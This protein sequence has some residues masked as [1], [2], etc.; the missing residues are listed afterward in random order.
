MSA[1]NVLLL[2]ENFFSLKILL[3]ETKVRSAKEVFT[4]RVN[5]VVNKY[6]AYRASIPNK[7]FM[8]C[9]HCFFVV[10]KSKSLLY[11]NVL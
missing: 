3:K 8:Y 2:A 1:G 4:L 9:D 6:K 7:Q 5:K 11:R 10:C